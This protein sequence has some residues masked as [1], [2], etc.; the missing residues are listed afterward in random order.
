MDETVVVISELRYRL[1]LS[2][3]ARQAA[4]LKSLVQNGYQ[5]ETDEDGEFRRKLFDALPSFQQLGY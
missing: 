3:T 4:Q 2:L 1:E 5:G